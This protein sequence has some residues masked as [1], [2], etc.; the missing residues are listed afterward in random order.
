MALIVV[1]FA[2]ILLPESSD[3]CL[4]NDDVRR[5]RWVFDGDDVFD[6]QLS[7]EDCCWN[8]SFGFCL[9]LA[10]GMIN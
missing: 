7:S 5:C 8:G 3:S 1:N 9:F 6:M 10:Y 4:V 2:L